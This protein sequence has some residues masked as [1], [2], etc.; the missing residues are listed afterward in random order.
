MEKRTAD[1]RQRIKT[2]GTDGI[3]PAK[4]Q[5]SAGRPARN[6]RGAPAELA[7]FSEPRDFPGGRRPGRAEK[8]TPAVVTGHSRGLGTHGPPRGSGGLG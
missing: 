8:K 1:Q 7:A 4:H 2:V 5:R 6:L 3:H